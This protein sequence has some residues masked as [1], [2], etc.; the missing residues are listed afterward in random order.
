MITVISPAKRLDFDSQTPSRRQS[1][2]AFPLQSERL[3]D[4]LRR[5]SP[6][7]LQKMMKISGQ[8]AELNHL[9]FQTWARPTKKRGARPA[10]YAFKGDVYMGL[11]AGNMDDEDLSFAQEHLLILSG[12][13]G[14]L[15]PLDLILPYR[16][17]MGTQ[18][19]TGEG[20]NLY[21][22]WGDTITH[23][24]NRKLRGEQNPTLIN[25]ASVEYFNSV[26]PALLNANIIS[27]AF[28]EWR[29]GRLKVVS[30]NAKRA[31]G[32]M[33]RYIVKKR[34]NDPELLKNFTEGGYAYHPDL[35]TEKLW[36]FVR[37]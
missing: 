37:A 27:P 3:V 30:F 33:S 35:S 28:K 15:R 10:I 23:H 13:H 31:R 4:H 21:E 12:L 36:S 25:L 8:L 26:K 19:D 2:A 7:A 6:V 1:R 32:L 29:G 14:V 16:L 22:F 11:D 18:F 24:L 20:A 9:R 5:F 34:I 17:E